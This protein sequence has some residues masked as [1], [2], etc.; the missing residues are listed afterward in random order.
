MK[1]DAFARTG[2]VPPGAGG[3]LSREE[4][5]VPTSAELARCPD[6]RREWAASR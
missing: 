2:Q 3:H 5:A 6:T 1:A 4:S